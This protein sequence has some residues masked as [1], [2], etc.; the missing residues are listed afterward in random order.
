[1]DALPGVV[2][3]VDVGTV[4]VGIARSDPQRTMALPVATLDRGP[5]T[6]AQIAALISDYEVV[7]VLVGLPL[8]LS[9]AQGSAAGAAISFAHDLAGEVAPCP[10]HLIDERLTTTQA[11]RSIA[12]SGRNQRSARGV[13]D[14]A[15][16]MVFLD[17]ALEAERRT[18]KMPGSRV[19]LEEHEGEG[20]APVGT[21]EPKRKAR[22]KSNK[23]PVNQP[24][25]QFQPRPSQTM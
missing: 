15:A 14:Q 25:Q 17:Y 18:G 1:M 2:L 8:T 10:V 5:A 3:A 24:P 11:G 23:K 22:H 9:G 13:I 16:A 7:A 4:R 19:N 21:P 20:G 6:L 12:A